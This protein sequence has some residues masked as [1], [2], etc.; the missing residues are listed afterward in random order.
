MFFLTF[1]SA[2]KITIVLPILKRSRIKLNRG[3]SRAREK[4]GQKRP[5]PRLTTN[6]SPPYPPSP[7]ISHTDP[8]SIMTS[9]YSSDSGTRI[10][11]ANVLIFV[12]VRSA[13][14]LARVMEL[15]KDFVNLSG[16]EN[17]PGWFDCG[18]L[19][20]PDRVKIP[21]KIARNSSTLTIL[22]KGAERIERVS[23]NLWIQGEMT[24]VLFAKRL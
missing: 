22:T 10:C 2:Q 24:L 7:E 5:L 16:G 17:A 1:V 20:Q 6:H 4:E 19:R 23:N 8:E 12:F 18:L 3:V 13:C 15:S 14:T 9:T 11:L 21:Q